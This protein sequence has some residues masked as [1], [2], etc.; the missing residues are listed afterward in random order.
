MPIRHTFAG[1]CA[2]T[3]RGHAAAE[4]PRRVMNSRHDRGGRRHTTVHV[5]F[6]PKAIVRSPSSD[7]SLVPLSTICT[8]A[9]KRAYSITSSVR[10]MSDGGTFEAEGL[11][12]FE[13]DCEGLTAI[14]K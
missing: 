13:I 1:C 2:R 9:K 11:G 8:A 6:A 4:P 7:L 10:A 14:R 5:R 3:A 12:G